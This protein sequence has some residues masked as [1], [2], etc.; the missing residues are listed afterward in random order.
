MVPES[1]RF[2]A[3]LPKSA[4]WSA[5]ASASLS[6]NCAEK[7]GPSKSMSTLPM[8]NTTF[9]IFLPPVAMAVPRPTFFTAQYSRAR[10]AR[11]YASIRKP[12]PT[13]SAEVCLSQATGSSSP[14]N[15]ASLA[16]SSFVKSLTAY[17]A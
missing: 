11:R 6:V 16:A 13:T 8:S 7:Y 4:C 12:S 17:T 9:L 10:T 2:Q 3:G 15:T 1:S 14:L 5:A